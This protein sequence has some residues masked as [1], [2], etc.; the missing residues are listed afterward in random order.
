MRKILSLRHICILNFKR[1][2]YYH[3]NKYQYQYKLLENALY[4]CFRL[5]ITN[6]LNE[7]YYRNSFDDISILTTN[8]KIL[9]STKKL[10]KTAHLY[11][12]VQN[13]YEQQLPYHT[14]SNWSI[15]TNKFKL[16]RTLSSQ[17]ET[18]SL[19]QSPLS[20]NNNDH[21][22]KNL[23]LNILTS[24]TKLI[25]LLDFPSLNNNHL[26]NYDMKTIINT[27]KLDLVDSSNQI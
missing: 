17:N 16:Q 27:Y 18:I 15:F 13:D 2:I 14:Q 12:L 21:P 19:P 1:S 11:S 23:V 20:N 4:Q 26:L 3:K 7:I 8:R 10:R 22:M 6:Q 24:S 5:N 25:D 9:K